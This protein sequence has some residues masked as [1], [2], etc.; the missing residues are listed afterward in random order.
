MI[1]LT[2]DLI[3]A[4]G[5]RRYCFVHSDDPNK[6]IKTLSP[7]GDPVKRRKEAV[8]YK[9]LLSALDDIFNLFRYGHISSLYL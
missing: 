6:C 4:E 8:W 7:N 1:K 9:K 5:G 2:D 3:F